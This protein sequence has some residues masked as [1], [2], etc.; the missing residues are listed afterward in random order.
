MAKKPTT[1]AADTAVEP[2]TSFAITEAQRNTVL[3]GLTGELLDSRRYMSGSKP[4]DE[5]GPMDSCCPGH[6]AR[7]EESKSRYAALKSKKKHVEATIALFEKP[8][9]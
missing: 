2:T 8:D 7:Y 6:L 4:A 3:N 1:T 5:P 9:R